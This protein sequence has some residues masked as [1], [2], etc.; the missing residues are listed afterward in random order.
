MPPATA[1]G[2]DTAPT[3]SRRMSTGASSPLIW[4]SI[5]MWR[6][7]Y[8]TPSFSTS[9][10]LLTLSGTLIMSTIISVPYF[11]P[12]S[13]ASD[14]VESSASPRT[15]TMSA[16]AF[17]M[18]STSNAPVSMV[19]VSAT[20]LRPGNVL[21]IV[22]TASVPSLLMRGVPT[23]IQSA[24]PSTASCAMP[25]LLLSCIMSRATCKTGSMAKPY[26]F[27]YLNGQ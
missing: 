24:P 3:I 17:A 22:R 2:T 11:L 21:F 20:I 5:P 9:F 18:I 25:T 6:Q 23:S 8:A 16:P 1:T 19:L 13:T 4:V 7:M 26:P 15:V 12:D 27:A 14:I 10:A